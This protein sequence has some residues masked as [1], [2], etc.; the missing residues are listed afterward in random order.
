LPSFPPGNQ[1]QP[2]TGGVG[3]TSLELRCAETT[4][5]SPN[6]LALCAAL[7]DIRVI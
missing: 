6:A 2:E 4:R 3:A 7:S 5:A 1:D